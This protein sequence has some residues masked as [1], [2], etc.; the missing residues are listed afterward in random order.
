[1][2]LSS[3]RPRC[4]FYG[5]H[6]PEKSRSLRDT[7]ANECALDFDGNGPCSMEAQGRAPDFDL[8]PL[9]AAI[10]PLLEA[11]KSNVVLFPAELGPEGVRLEAWTRQVMQRT[12]KAR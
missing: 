5:F 3:N 8:C 2:A 6:W 7:G 9:V 12:R 4:P 1:M 10:R 11:A